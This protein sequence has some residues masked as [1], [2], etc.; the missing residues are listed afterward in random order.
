MKD[1][2]ARKWFIRLTQYNETKKGKYLY[3][4]DMLFFKLCKK[5]KFVMYIVHD[6]DIKNIHSHFVIHND[7]PIRFSTLKKLLPYGSIEK[8]LGSNR[9][10]YDYL[11][12]KDKVDSYSVD[13]VISN[14]D[15]LDVW[16]GKSGSNLVD[17]LDLIENGASDLELKTLFPFFYS[18]YNNLIQKHRQ[19]I[20]KKQAL[21]FRKLEVHYLYGGSGTGKSYTAIS[22]NDISDIYIVNSYDRGSFDNYNNEKVVILEEYRGNW[23]L[24]KLLQ[25]LDIYPLQLS[26]RYSNKWALFEKVY[27]ISNIPLKEQYYNLDLESEK[28][29]F[30]RINSI[31]YFTNDSIYYFNNKLELINTIDNPIK[32]IVV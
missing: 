5:Y 7:V 24:S 2:Q 23:Q 9:Q 10:V 25:F 15:N 1:L 16:L 19:V 4:F 14:I 29:L 12:H 31:R 28:A 8:Q 20:Y 6:K 21:L 17:F 3:D 18:R 11:I 30:R 22:E 26:A 32:K 13:K 27:I